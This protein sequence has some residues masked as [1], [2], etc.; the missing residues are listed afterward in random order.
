VCGLFA[1]LFPNGVGFWLG[2]ETSPLTD[3]SIKRLET[4]DGRPETGDQRLE[5]KREEAGGWR[6]RGGGGMCY[7]SFTIF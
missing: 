1:Y 5:E 7:Y 4:G 2:H 3:H 6:R